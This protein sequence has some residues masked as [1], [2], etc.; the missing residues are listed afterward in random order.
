MVLMENTHG[1]VRVDAYVVG[2]GVDEVR[3]MNIVASCE[4]DVTYA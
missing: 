4:S 1:L 2:G 3:K